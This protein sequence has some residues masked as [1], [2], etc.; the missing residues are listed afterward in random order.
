MAQRFPP[1]AG[2]QRPFATSYGYNDYD[3][4]LGG[5]EVIDYSRQT[6]SACNP[7]C[8]TKVVAHDCSPLRCSLCDRLQRLFRR[9][10]FIA[11]RFI[12][13]GCTRRVRS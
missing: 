9:H 2:L 13:S 12:P 8:P 3:D 1:G 10:P 4:T 11:T 5:H 6:V 7:L